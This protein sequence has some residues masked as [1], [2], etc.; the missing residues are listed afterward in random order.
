MKI[1]EL[2]DGFVMHLRI[3]SGFRYDVGL[4]RPVKHPGADIFILSDGYMDI[5]LM[6]PP[7]E[8]SSSSF[9]ALVALSKGVGE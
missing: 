4:Y 9:S 1:K 7:E 3:W 2:T 6:Q 5:A 8:K